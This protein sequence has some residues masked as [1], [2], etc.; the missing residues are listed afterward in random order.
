MVM[1]PLQYSGMRPVGTRGP[2]TCSL[3]TLPKVKVNERTHAPL[4]YIACMHVVG[5]V[6]EQSIARVLL[7]IH[8]SSLL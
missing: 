4:G 6:A 3:L 5:D 2:P 8:S 7:D 1:I